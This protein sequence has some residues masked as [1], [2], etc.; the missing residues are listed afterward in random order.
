MT[1][2]KHAVQTPTPNP[3]PELVNYVAN[4]YNAKDGNF[5][6]KPVFFL[7]YVQNQTIDWGPEREKRDIPDQ[8]RAS[9][10]TTH[11]ETNDSLLM[12]EKADYDR[13][14]SVSVDAE[15]S[16]V[17]FSG[18]LQS[19]LLYHGSLFSSTSSF[20][21]LNLYLQSVLAFERK[22]LKLDSDFVKAI[23]TLPTEIGA[24]KNQQAYFQF[25]DDYGTHYTT[26]GTMGGTIVMETDIKDS[27]LDTSTMLD[28]SVGVRAGYQG[29]LRS[30]SLDVKAAYSSSEFLSK[31]RNEV[32]IT[33]N[34]MGGLYAPDE[35]I[36]EWAKSIYNTPSLLL[37][38]P[39]L[40]SN[41]LTRLKCISALVATAGG[42]PVIAQ[43]INALIHSYLLAA[44]QDDGL[45]TSPKDIPFGQVQDA[46]SGDG[47]VISFIEETG[48]GARGYIQALDD[49]NANP[50]T[51]R[52][53]AS[54]HYF[55]NS[56]KW[57]TSTSL[58]MP[59]PHGT[60]YLGESVPTFG[61]PRMM[62]RFVGLGDSGEQAMGPWQDV[63][64]NSDIKV[65]T[66]GFV[67]AYVD[68][69]NRDGARG[70]V[71]GLQKSGNGTYT[72]V[73]AA[74]QHY[75]T[76]SDIQVPSN[77]F[78]MPVRK[79]TTYRVDLVVTSSG[80]TAKA[81]FVPLS[82]ALVLFDSFQS[83]KENV[84]YQ[85]H[86]DGF[87]I[88]YLYTNNDG[89]RGHVDLFAYPDQNELTRLGKLATTS[90]HYYTNRDIQVPYNT[91]TIPVS[92]NSFY[93]A[94]FTRTAGSPNV[95]VLW[96]PLGIKPS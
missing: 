20:Y 15:F 72:V 78:C 77:S 88:A 64:L 56:D 91:A 12:E 4:A 87:L 66:D 92:K 81:Y 51:M 95:Q 83:R 37:N 49:K 28:V 57:V 65:L 11:Y 9:T 25:F 14:F 73:A 68:W 67:V 44:T 43:N 82:E 61:S 52:A 53:A 71:Q 26:F 18:S 74:S 5:L 1:V 60:T 69:N 21:S 54:Q 41:Q 70:Y 27:I 16:G 40:A 22:D 94:S 80:S 30:G 34:V 3:P 35:K 36:V 31:H 96:I 85:A 19:S 45:L 84:I 58:T 55:T 93:I 29:V 90:V 46:N 38:V 8:I 48:N 6:S 39:K 42:N 63:E 2:S 23:T 50:T 13:S 7:S 75:Y 76:G 24:V 17:S 89:D 33:L 79:D 62:Q 59:T 47:F 32:S 86:T 10:A